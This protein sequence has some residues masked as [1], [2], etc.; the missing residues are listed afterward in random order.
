LGSRPGSGPP[1]GWGRRLRG[2]GRYAGARERGLSR[3]FT[4]PGSFLSEGSPPPCN[5]PNL[6]RTGGARPSRTWRRTGSCSSGSGAAARR[7]ARS[8]DRPSS[9]PGPRPFALPPRRGGVCEQAGWS[10]DQ[11]GGWGLGAPSIAGCVCICVCILGEVLAYSFFGGG[12]YCDE[13]Q[14]TP[15]PVLPLYLLSAFPPRQ[16]WN[17]LGF[18]LS[19]SGS[20]TSFPFSAR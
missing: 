16:L 15:P 1:A 9:A 4:L 10:W 20:L 7:S 18:P 12:A 11:V 6:W 8:S 14:S 5:S 2:R 3:G 13:S 17:I 19:P